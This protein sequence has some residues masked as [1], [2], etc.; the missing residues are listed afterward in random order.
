[1]A[2]VTHEKE[3]L[4]ST[5]TAPSAWVPERPE[6]GPDYY[7]S[8]REELKEFIAKD[9]LVPMPSVMET[10]ATRT[11]SLLTVDI[12]TRKFIPVNREPMEEALKA[13]NI[14]AK[15]CPTKKPAPSTKQAPVP[16]SE[17]PREES[18]KKAS[19]SEWTEV[20]RRRAKVATSPL[21]KQQQQQQELPEKAAVSQQQEQNADTK[22]QQ[23][24]EGE[25]QQ[26]ERVAVK[27]HQQ[28]SDGPS[29]GA[30]KQKQLKQQH[31][32]Q[33]RREQRQKLRDQ[34]REQQH[35]Q[36]RQPAQQELEQQQQQ[37]AEKA[38]QPE[39]VDPVKTLP[40]LSLSLSLF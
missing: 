28:K 26:Q 21:Q 5:S 10:V 34:Q 36:Q 15:T 37:L 3:P 6:K 27:Q 20:V 17:V 16:T 38:V 19:G 39:Q 8:R 9:E 29:K 35:E 25:K 12:K 14:G 2:E 1:M 13:L 30:A 40:T 18:T 22:K 33:Q 7:R 11:I 23:D 31:Q 32:V 24:K 4:A